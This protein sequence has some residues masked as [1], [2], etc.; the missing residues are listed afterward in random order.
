MKTNI[1]IEQQHSGQSYVTHSNLA[2][3][4]VETVCCK[5]KTQKAHS[6]SNLP[7]P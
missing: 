4:E 6:A 1:S 5:S 7:S 2:G 3:L